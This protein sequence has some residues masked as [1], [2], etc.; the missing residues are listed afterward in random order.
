MGEGP[1]YPNVNFEDVPAWQFGNVQNFD[2]E[3]NQGWDNWD[4]GQDNVND[5]VDFLPEIPQPTDVLQINSSFAS[6]ILA[7]NSGNSGSI[8]SISSS[9]ASEIGADNSL[10]VQEVSVDANVLKNLCQRFP[11]IMFDKNFVKDA[12]FWSALNSGSVLG[13]SNWASGNDVPVVSGANEILDPVPLAVA[14][15]P[16]VF[17]ALTDSDAPVKPAKRTYKKRAVGSATPVVATGLRSSKRLLAIFDARKLSFKDDILVEPDPNQ[18]IG[19]PRGKSVKKLKQVAHEVGLLFSGSSL[20]ESDFMEGTAEVEGPAD[21]PIPLLQKMATDLCG[22]APQD[23]TQESLLASAP[24]S[25][26]DES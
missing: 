4:E 24:K 6:S 23:V 12:S 13:T 25:V 8:I 10:M 3:E 1:V 22:V 7:V 16:S 2:Q 18:G 11:Q 15:P 14:P 19:K 5:N 17:L 21:C 26:D 20:Q 9:E